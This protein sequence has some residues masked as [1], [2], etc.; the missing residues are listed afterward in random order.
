MDSYNNHLSDNLDNRHHSASLN[1]Y[2]CAA[3]FGIPA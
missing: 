2:L 1:L 3:D